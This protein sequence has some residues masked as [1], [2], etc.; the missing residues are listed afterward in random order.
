[1]LV[2]VL[3]GDE[4]LV[5][6][7][8]KDYLLRIDITSIPEKKKGAI[9]VKGMKLAEDE[10]LSHIYAISS[11]ENKTVKI[12]GKNIALNRLHIGTRGTKGVKK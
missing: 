4:T 7:S 8:E 12:K 9:G 11:G 2:H 3:Q 1:M 5:M 10:S 6:Q